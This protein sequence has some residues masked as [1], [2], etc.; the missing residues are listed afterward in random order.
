MV[1]SQETRKRINQ[2]Q[3]ENESHS[4]THKMNYMKMTK[5][6]FWQHRILSKEEDQESIKQDQ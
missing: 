1:K 6:V 5:A 3:K 4:Q 2:D